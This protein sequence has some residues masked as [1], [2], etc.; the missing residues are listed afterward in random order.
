MFVEKLVRCRLL[1]AHRWERHRAE[2]ETYW[3]CR[4]CGKRYFGD[5]PPEGDDSVFLQASGSSGGP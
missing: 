5:E 1:A 2:G 4:T 3:E